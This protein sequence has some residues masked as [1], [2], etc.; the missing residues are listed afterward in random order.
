TR[1]SVVVCTFEALTLQA[2]D[3]TIPRVPKGMLHMQGKNKPDY[4]VIVIG[5]GASGGWACKRLSEAGLKVALLEAGKPQ[6]D[7]NFS[8]HK[9]AFELKYRKRAAE[10]GRTTRPVQSVFDACNEYTADWFVNY[11]EEPYTAP[12]DQSF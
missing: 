12:K 11:L 6:S 1:I 9:P 5:S 2:R 10:I 4:D 3:V 8:E 7:Q